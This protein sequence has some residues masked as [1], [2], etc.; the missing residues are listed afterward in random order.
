MSQLKES[1]L[2]D[3]GASNEAAMQGWRR[4]IF[5]ITFV[6]YAMAH[7]ARKCYT[8]VKTD[9]VEAGVD[10]IILSQMD[11]AFM[12]TYAIGSFISGRL[13]DTFPQNVIIGWGLI[14]S[15]FCLG[16]IWFFFKI[17]VV[18][19]SYSVG[20]FL[21]VLAQF[22]HGFFQ[23][24][25]GPVNTSV[26]GNWFPKKGRGLVFGLWTCHQY[27]G[28]IISGL[29]TAAIVNSGY[30]WQW[31]LLLPGLFSGLWGLVNF[32]S[33]PN[34]PSDVGLGGGEDKKVA[35]SSGGGGG[36]GTIGFMQALRIPNVLAYAIAFGFFKFVNY[37]MFFWLPFFLSLHFD[38]Q[39]A[40]VISSLYSFGMMPGGVIVGWVSD[41]FG[42]RRACV[43]AVFMAFLAPLLYIFALFSGTMPP[44]LLL[45]LLC[46]M[47]ILVGGPNNI[48]TS[49]VAADLAD[50]PSIGGNTRALGTVTG[51]I[52]GSGSIT[53]ALGL[54]LIG[55]LQNF[56]G[57]TAV[58]YFLIFCVVVGTALMSPNIVK[59]LKR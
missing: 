11:M 7:V 19:S 36:G 15:T 52:N 54:M 59:E 41:L 55:P 26:M 34:E 49:A 58:W 57:W 47:G 5:L 27:V 31:A 3:G 18:H 10:K 17:D 56:G 4:R 21:F 25:G 35:V 32:A 16:L 8:N 29:A 23:S 38:P 53:A 30:S 51:I 2:T 44:T 6:N 14:G 24:T 42:G 22:I 40:N 13:G 39:A 46:I 37:A 50:D 45:C 28:D 12:F 1:L 20:F 9:L 43:I 48:I 33:L